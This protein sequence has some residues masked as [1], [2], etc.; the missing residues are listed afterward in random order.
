MTQV[1]I[2]PRIEDPGSTTEPV[3]TT[4]WYTVRPSRPVEG[5]QWV[6]DEFP[7]LRPVSTTPA[8]LDPLAFAYELQ[9]FSGDDLTK[10]RVHEFRIVPDSASVLNWQQLEQVAGPGSTPPVLSELEVRVAALETSSPSG[11]ASNV[12]EVDGISA[13]SQ[14]YLDDTSA[15]AVRATIG[16]GTASTK[17]DVGLGSVDNT[18]DTAKPIST[19]TQAALDLKAPLASPAF[20][21]NPTAPTPTAGDNDTS[22]ATTAFV[23]AAVAA[24]PSANP[25][26]AQIQG[27]PA[28]LDVTVYCPGD[29]QVNRPVP[30]A[31][32]AY[33]VTWL[34]ATAPTVGGSFAV[35][36]DS[37]RPWSG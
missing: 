31:G 8:D 17:T 35:A 29:V 6:L 14:T 34:K 33:H 27:A 23:T 19:A 37:W 2:A 24:G 10:P 30:P 28:N 5:A 26:W 9:L 32:L 4:W 7:P 25:T 20:T 11:G 18:A 22:I 15:A 21:G 12:T 3:L 16:A 13:F 1:L 36:G